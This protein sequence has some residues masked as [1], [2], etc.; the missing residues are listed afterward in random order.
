MPTGSRIG[1]GAAVGLA[2]L[3]AAMAVL[4][5][6]TATAGAQDT[7]DPALRRVQLRWIEPDE[8]VV[9]PVEGGLEPA[10]V[11]EV[12]AVGYPSDTT[13]RVR[14]CVTGATHRCNRSLTVRTDHRGQAVFQ[15]LVTDRIDS[16]GRCRLASAQRCTVELEIGDRLTVVDTV[17]VDAAPTPGRL[18]ID[19]DRDLEIGETVTVEARG[20]PAGRELSLRVC[21]APA[22]R[23][24]R[25]GAPGPEATVLTDATG[26]ARA[27]LTLDIDEVGAAGIACARRTPCQIVATSTAVGVWS[28]PVRLDLATTPGVGYDGAR[29]AV[30]LLLAALLAAS[31]ARLI[32]ATDWQPPAEADSSLIDDA[33]WADLDAEAAAFDEAVA[34]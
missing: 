33:T 32:R 8:T 31:A 3:I 17:F 19:P 10:T 1:S 2:T 25:C 13:G 20:F 26:S 18:T 28:A 29:L 11:L 30:G 23:G 21:A 24:D 9:A 15:F 27:T 5:A 14:Q 22:T 12:N 4:F 7:E 16:D 6:T 34:R